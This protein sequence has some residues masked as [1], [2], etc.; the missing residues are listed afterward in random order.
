MT[1]NEYQTKL[2]EINKEEEKFTNANNIVDTSTKLGG[3]FFGAATACLIIGTELLF[4][5][6]G[7]LTAGLCLGNYLNK[8]HKENQ[9]NEYNKERKEAKEERNRTIAANN[10]RQQANQQQRQRVVTNGQAQQQVQPLPPRNTNN[11]QQ[12]QRVAANGQAQQQVQPLPPRNT[13]A[14]Q[15]L[16]PEEEALVDAYINGLIAGRRINAGRGKVKIK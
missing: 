13:N 14:Q 2:N 10:Q 1:E 8:K 5:P 16:T 9:T 4:I 11:Q 12:R 7:V 3:A 6:C 15:N